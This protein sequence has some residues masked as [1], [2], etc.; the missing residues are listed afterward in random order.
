[1][2]V[3]GN[4]LN[5]L[6]EWREVDTFLLCHTLGLENH[7]IV[8]GLVEEVNLEVLAFPD[9]RAARL[10]D[11]GTIGVG[12][13]QQRLVEGIADLALGLQHLGGR[14]TLLG[15]VDVDHFPTPATTA[16]THLDAWISHQVGLGNLALDAL[17]Q[18]AREFNDDPS[19]TC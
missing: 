8:E 10:A 13:L 15:L 18:F 6:D 17:W 1:M 16:Q 4:V 7:E 19:T 11:G 3:T 5:D 9:E 12:L 2:L 14:H